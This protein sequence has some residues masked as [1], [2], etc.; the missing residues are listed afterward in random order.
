MLNSF[1]KYEKIKT[2]LPKAKLLKPLAEK[3]I[4]KAKKN[5]LHS[6]RIV[7]KYLRKW[8][9]IPKIFNEIAPRYKERPGGYTQILRLGYR[10]SDGAEIALLK[11]VEEFQ[12]V[13]SKPQK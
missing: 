1:F 4:T 5:D 9:V 11:L 12:K 2:T 8:D 13:E 3:I 7:F 6:K 10:N